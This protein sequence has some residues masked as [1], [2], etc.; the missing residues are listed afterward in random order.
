M[1]HLCTVAHYPVIY[2]KPRRYQ[3]MHRN[4]KLRIARR[5]LLI[6]N[7]RW[8]LICLNAQ[9]DINCSNFNL[10]RRTSSTENCQATKQGVLYGGTSTRGGGCWL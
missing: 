1:N 9:I 3:Q 6:L 7:S 4:R 10:L 8:D 2:L 5:V